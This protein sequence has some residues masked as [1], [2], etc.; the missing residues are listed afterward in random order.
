[1]MGLFNYRKDDNTT[2]DSNDVGYYSV[3]GLEA[4]SEET[5][6]DDDTLAGLSCS[7][8]ETAK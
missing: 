7:D 8:G 6:K 4:A 1:M 5:L 2:Y 3:L